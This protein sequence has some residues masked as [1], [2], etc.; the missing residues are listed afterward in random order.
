MKNH[1]LL[2]LLAV[3]SLFLFGFAGCS[4]SSDTSDS[5]NSEKTAADESKIYKI[6]SSI[7]AGKG[8]IFTDKTSAENGAKVGVVIDIAYSYSLGALSVQTESGEDVQ[9]EKIVENSYYQFAMPK[10]NVK[11]TV[12]FDMVKSAL[13]TKAKDAVKEVGDIV[14]ADGTA[15]PYDEYN[16][17][18]FFLTAYQKSQAIAVI[19][20]KGSD[21]C[22]KGEEKR[23]R[24]LGIGM[25]IGYDVQW[26][27]NFSTPAA[28]SHELYF[29]DD[30]ICVG[31]DDGYDKYIKP[32]YSG[33][34]DGSKNLEKFGNFL[35]KKG[36]TD[37]TDDVSK[38]PAFY[39]A[40]NYSAHDKSRVSGT[41]YESGWFLPSI[42]EIYKINDVK[43]KVVK[44]IKVCD[45]D[46]SM[47]PGLNCWSSS[48]VPNKGGPSTNCVYV[49]RFGDAHFVE[50]LITYTATCFAIRE[51]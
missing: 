43:E 21:L 40:K 22:S 24:M 41:E 23:E 25:A 48:G 50:G 49:S 28:V 35:K 9:Y 46:T 30:I 45:G 8:I 20:Y 31:Q 11:V 10:S 14:F 26:A 39:F 16:K 44:G 38:Y 27:S 15:T 2:L 47:V 36:Y 32:P 7:A 51:F 6:T 17:E 42:A 19:F 3:C 29:Y 5:S 37:D 18:G 33:C 13:G 1:K 34:L 4:E 12:T